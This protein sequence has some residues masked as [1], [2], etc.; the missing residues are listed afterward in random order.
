MATTARSCV[1]MSQVSR[2]ASHTERFLFY[3]IFAVISQR[4]S[5]RVLCP[6]I[7]VFISPWY[8][9]LVLFHHT[10][11]IF[12][13]ASPCRVIFAQTF[14]KTC[15]DVEKRVGRT[16]REGPHTFLFLPLANTL[17]VIVYF[18]FLFNSMIPNPGE[19]SQKD[20][21]GCFEPN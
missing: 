5:P 15:T 14:A 4:H 19:D 18:S 3:F 6:K 11:T 17:F 9:V 8:L 2:L 16:V 1:I 20:R 7:H 21:A 13:S 10:F 12:P